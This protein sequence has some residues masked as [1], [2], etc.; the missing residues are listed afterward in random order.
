MTTTYK[1]STMKNIE[2]KKCRNNLTYSFHHIAHSTYFPNKS[3]TIQ[4]QT[5]HIKK[6]KSL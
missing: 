5:R 2:S 4:P 6:H 1:L 3:E